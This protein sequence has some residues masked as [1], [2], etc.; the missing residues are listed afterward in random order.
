[1]THVLITGGAGYVGALLTPRLLQA[2]Y[3]V[4]VYDIM[5]YGRDH[6]PPVPGLRVI[7]GDIRDTAKLAAAF[8]GVDQVI[9]L[10]CISNDPSFELDEA[11][12][13]TINLDAFEPM[14]KAAKAAGVKRFIYASSS[15]VYGVSDAPDVT[16]EHPK[17]P[18]TLYSRFKLDCEEILWRHQSA[19][20]VCVTLRPATV[21]GF[22]P[23][24]RLD[25]SVNILTNHAVNNGRIRVFGGSQLRPNLHIADM[26]DAYRLF[27]EAPDAKVAGQTFNI[28]YENLSI[29][30]IA[31][32]VRQV[33]AQEFPD[34]PEVPIVVEPTNDLR[35]YH[36]NSDRVAE[37]MGFRPRHTVEE[38]IRDLCRAFKGGLL[39]DSMTDQRYFNVAT[40]KALK[41]S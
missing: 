40:M 2:G 27:L 11:L 1:M 3:R 34:R 39:P 13:K 21:C 5:Y 31:E 38:A 29:M 26:C 6:L 36:V 16:E 10:A 32:R 41:A 15:S 22:S 33:V 19:G 12:S 24:Q 25:L 37:V 35:S 8:E 30:A 23:R 28:G 17:N 14:V 9:H 18:L 4:S 7:P 20:F